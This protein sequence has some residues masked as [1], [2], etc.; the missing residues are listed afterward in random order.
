MSE[1]VQTINKENASNGDEHDEGVLSTAV[2]EDQNE[3]VN[4]FN[5]RSRGE[6]GD[7]LEDAVIASSSSSSSCSSRGPEV[8]SQNEILSEE[9]VELQSDDEVDD[10][11]IDDT[12][13]EGRN[14]EGDVG[15]DILG[16]EDDDIEDV[17]G[18]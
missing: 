14:L 11:E 18:E 12:N 4:V 15:S 1:N 2:S 7:M 16:D 9:M 10:A 13:L 8:N 3:D 5:S 6:S 17:D